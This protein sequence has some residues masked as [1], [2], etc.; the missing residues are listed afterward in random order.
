MNI[1]DT[2]APYGSRWSEKDVRRFT[3]EEISMVNKA[4]VVDS[5][6]GTSC[7]FF[8]KSG[9]T[10]FI[11]MSNDSKSMT[12]DYVDLST[13]ELITLEKPGEEDIVRVRG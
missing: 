6:Y 8:M 12:G 2:L 5:K 1:F 10:K 4:M 11:P 3:P 9:V 13:A 7:C